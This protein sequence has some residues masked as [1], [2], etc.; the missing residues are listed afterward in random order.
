MA[1]SGP[2][3]VPLITRICIALAAAAAFS[4]CADPCE[5]LAGRIC[6]CQVEQVNQTACKTRMKDQLKRGPKPT[7][8]DNDYCIDLMKTCPDPADDPSICARL[9][10][11]QGKVSCGLA[12]PPAL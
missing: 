12:Y 10:Q 2:A 4:A 7:G 8:A 1:F 3:M 6:D 11:D 5:E 9:D